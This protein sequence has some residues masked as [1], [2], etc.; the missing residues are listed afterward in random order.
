[1]CK[2]FGSY[3]ALALFYMHKNESIFI[4]IHTLY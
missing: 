2:I 3:E 4:N 1:M